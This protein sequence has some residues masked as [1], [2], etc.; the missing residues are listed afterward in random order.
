MNG[1]ATTVNGDVGTDG[2]FTFN[3]HPT[4]TGSVIFDGAGA[5][6]QSP[7][8][9]TYVVKYN[10]AAVVWPTV[11]QLAV[12]TF[13]ATGLAYVAA[14]NDNALASPAIPTSGQN[15]NMVLLNGNGTQT[16][17]G[18]AGGANYYLRA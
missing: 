14:H 13:G 9:G 5:G 11:E 2:F 18:K 1:S 6:W 3:G 10:A 17:V 15:A 8:N 16:F 4:I 7:P 12:T